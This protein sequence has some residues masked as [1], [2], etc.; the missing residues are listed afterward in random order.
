MRSTFV[1]WLTIAAVFSLGV[2]SVSPARADH[3]A[4]YNYTGAP[5]TVFG[6]DF[7]CVNGNPYTDTSVTGEVV[8]D[9]STAQQV[10]IVDTSTSQVTTIY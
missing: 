8:V 2:T 4:E 7:G 5:F 6:C 10:E 3:I 1:T 9:T